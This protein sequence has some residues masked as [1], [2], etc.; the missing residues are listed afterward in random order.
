MVA[1]I[2]ECQFCNFTGGA[3]E[4]VR[5][6]GESQHLIRIKPTEK[7]FPCCSGPT[8][9]PWCEDYVEEK[10]ERVPADVLTEMRQLTAN[11]NQKTRVE[12]IIAR[13]RVHDLSGIPN[14]EY[15]AS[16]ADVKLLI[17]ERTHSP[18]LLTQLT[19]K[20]ERQA[21]TMARLVG[22]RDKARGEVGRLRE[23]LQQIAAFDDE[24][25]NLILRKRGDY[26]GFDEPG[27]VQTAREALNRPAEQKQKGK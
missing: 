10:R 8:H 6:R 18:S 22:E 25:A 16:W 7:W 11:W 5:H 27:A 14:D 1:N 13:H 17:D 19:T 26:S 4:A 9:A 3:I 23:A 12:Q 24:G 20:L 15:T 21:G 2:Y